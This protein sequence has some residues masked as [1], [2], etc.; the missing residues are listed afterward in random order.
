[1]EKVENRW[2]T[3]STETNQEV[4]LKLHLL[5]KL[6]T[7]DDM[8]SGKR[9]ERNHAIWEYRKVYNTDADQQ[10]YYCIS[11]LLPLQ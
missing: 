7:E 9:M 1:M 4:V 5:L 2:S 3:L 11:F 8:G 6:M 10:I